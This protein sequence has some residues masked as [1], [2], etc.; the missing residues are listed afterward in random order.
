MHTKLL[1]PSSMA[2]G[3]LPRWLKQ[4]GDRIR[5]GEVIAEVETDKALMEIESP[6]EGML[7]EIEVPEGSASV[8]ADALLALLAE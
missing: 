2:N 3:T 1:M 7:V 4:V 8:P 6:F 5:A